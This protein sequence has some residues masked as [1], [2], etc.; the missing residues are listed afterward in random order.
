MESVRI[1]K[2]G[3]VKS[4]ADATPKVETEPG[5]D[6]QLIA[7]PAPAPPQ[8]DLEPA[9]AP[10]A[11]PPPAVPSKPARGERRTGGRYAI[12]GAGVRTRAP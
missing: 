6:V 12:D 2:R 7:S 4:G 1:F 3:A 8:A 5:P 11:E 9:P 10:I